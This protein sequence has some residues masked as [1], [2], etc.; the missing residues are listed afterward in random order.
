MT[1]FNISGIS[2]GIPASGI[3]KVNDEEQVKNHHVKKK[4]KSL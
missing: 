4:P 2:A 3:G 1:D